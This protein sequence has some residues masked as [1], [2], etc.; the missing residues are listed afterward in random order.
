MTTTQTPAGG[1]SRRSRSR[2]SLG[3]RALQLSA[4]GLSFTLVALLVVSTSQQ[5]FSAQTDNSANKVSTATINLTDND[6]GAAMFNVAD[7]V[8]G[9]NYDRCI[10]VTYTGLTNPKGIKLYLSTAP[11]PATLAPYLNVTVDMATA[12]PSHVFSDC[13]GFGSPTSVVA[14]KKL[15]AMMVGSYSANN[16]DTWTP[17]ASGQARTFRFR[18]SVDDVAAAQSTEATGFAFKWEVQSN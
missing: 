16:F 11:S 5:A 6:A 8:P 12:I 10:T 15:S 3:G 18:V 4:V 1:R 13:S 7:A 9:T 17:T 2:R 14:T